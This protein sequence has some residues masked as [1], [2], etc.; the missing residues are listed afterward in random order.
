MVFIAYGCIIYLKFL[1]YH[2]HNS[3][4][5]IDT[6]I[7]DTKNSKGNLPLPRDKLLFVGVICPLVGIKY[8]LL[9][10]SSP[11]MSVKYPLVGKTSTV[12]CAMVLHAR[13]EA[14]RNFYG[15]T[16]NFAFTF[17]TEDN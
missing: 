13:R 5:P 1:L 10:Y 17:R 15:L 12:F 16:K 8:P 14:F 3:L 6:A 9:R 2:S 4:C 7:H 11:L